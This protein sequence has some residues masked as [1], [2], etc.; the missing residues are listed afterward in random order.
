MQRRWEGD[1]PLV[2]GYLR[3]EDVV[4]SPGALGQIVARALIDA[5]TDRHALT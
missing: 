1:Y 4:L 2:S 3:I 5:G